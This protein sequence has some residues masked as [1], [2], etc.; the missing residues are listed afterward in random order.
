MCE[1]ESFPE[2]QLASL[3]AAKVYYHLQE[4]NESMVFALGAGKLFNIEE[5]GEF[6]ETIICKNHNVDLRGNV[7]TRLAKCIDTFI[8]ISATPE[9]SK[10]RSQSISAFPQSTNGA[11]STSAGLTSP[12]TPFSQSTLPSKSLLSR[13]E[14]GQVGSESNNVDGATETPLVLQRGV[15]GQLKAVI[16]RLFELCFQHKRYRQ[17]IGI[18]VE[19]KNLEILKTAILRATEDE[20]Q[21]GGEATRVGEELMEYVL[22]ICMNVVQERAF[23]NQVRRSNRKCL[24]I[25]MLMELDSRFSS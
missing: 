8:S 25:A 16:E 17:V 14:E 23:R 15:Q 5:G 7:L 9:A 3:L 10:S 12:I 24:S 22:G 21:H 18:A 19:A 20:K 13:Q 11:T 2:R 1:D 6:E 4:Y